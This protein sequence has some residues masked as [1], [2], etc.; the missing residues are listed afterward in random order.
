MDLPD[1]TVL[2]ELQLQ[3]AKTVVSDTFSPER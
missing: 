1:F 2:L 3:Q